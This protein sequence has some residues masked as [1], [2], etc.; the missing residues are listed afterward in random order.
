MSDTRTLPERPIPVHLGLFRLAKTMLMLRWCALLLA[1]LP[2]LVWGA[3]CMVECDWERLQLAIVGGSVTVRVRSELPPAPPICAGSREPIGMLR[4][5]RT[6][7]SFSV[8]FWA[9]S[10]AFGGV[11]WLA[12]ARR[13]PVRP[14][15]CARCSYDLTGN[16]SGLC[17]ECGSPVRKQRGAPSPPSTEAPANCTTPRRSGTLKTRPPARRRTPPYTK[18]CGEQ[19]ANGG[20]DDK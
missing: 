6:L 13:P 2:L 3:G 7:A 10:V 14:G 12:W 4:I 8:P 15:A 19:L 5:R 1:L 17:P 9:F 11:S 16:V 20:L 18:S